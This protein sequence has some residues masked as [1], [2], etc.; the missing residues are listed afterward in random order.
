MGYSNRRDRKWQKTILVRQYKDPIYE[1]NVGR[2]SSVGIAI[3]YG[4]DVPAIESRW[5]QGFPHPS[6]LAL[7]PNQY[8]IKWV[9]SLS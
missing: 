7:G 8:L 4:V 2:D 1:I 5:G 3:H 9:P 6:R